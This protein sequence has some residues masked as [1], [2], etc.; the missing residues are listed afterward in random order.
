M[1][2]KLCKS[3]NPASLNTTL[4]LPRAN[5]NFRRP[6]IGDQP[7]G[8]PIGWVSTETWQNSLNVL[9]KYSGLK[10]TDPSAYFTND[11]IVVPKS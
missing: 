2:K 5:S 7:R 4:N 8:K 9:S 11:F 6:C 1:L 10:N 3:A